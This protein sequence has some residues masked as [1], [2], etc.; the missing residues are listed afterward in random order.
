MV[1]DGLQSIRGPV[2]AV[3]RPHCPVVVCIA[4]VAPQDDRCDPSLDRRV[5]WQ[6]DPAWPRFRRFLVGTPPIL[7]LQAV[8]PG[9]QLLLEA[10]M[11]QIRKKSVL[12]SDCLI[13]LYDELLAPIGF[14]LGSPRDVTKRGSHVTLKHPEAYRIN[15]AMIS[16][17][18]G[19]PAIIPDFR[20]PD[21]LRLGIAPLFLSHQDIV[22]AVF[23]IREIV[24]N[25][26]YENFGHESDTVT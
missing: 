13:A 3:V 2:D 8:E 6:Q 14:I 24:V 17:L 4:S 5:L 20:T 23:R 22:R 18:E 16:P 11:D 10:G 25:R 21:N 26:E 1:F 9:I 12:Q 7:S 19:K 15:K